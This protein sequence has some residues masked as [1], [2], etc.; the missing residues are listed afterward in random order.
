MLSARANVPVMFKEVGLPTASG[1]DHEIRQRDEPIEYYKNIFSPA[2]PGRSCRF[3]L[4]RG[5]RSRV[6]GIVGGTVVGDVSCQQRSQG[7]GEPCLQESVGPA[8]PQPD[9]PAASPAAAS[10]AAASPA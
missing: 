10:P 1:K 9:P 7:G 2:V 8:P 5:F 4:L 6:E 3:R